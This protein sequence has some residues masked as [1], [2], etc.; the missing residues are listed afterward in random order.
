MNL[1]V[2]RCP[3][4]TSAHT[5]L[6]HEVDI[7]CYYECKSC[8]VIFISPEVLE[9]VD[10]GLGLVHYTGSYWGNELYSSRE[11]S[12]GSSLARVAELFLYAR[13]PINKFIDIA[14]GPGY[15]LDSLK[16]QLPSSDIFY[17]NELFPPDPEFCTS[18]SNYLRGS[19]LDFTF[20]FEAGCCIEVIE[21][22]SPRMVKQLFIDLAQRSKENS[23]YIFNTGLA[24]Y[25]KKE[26]IGYLDPLERGHIMG[27]SIKSLQHL[28]KPIGFNIQPIPGKTWAFIAEYKTNHDF[29]GPLLDR[30]WIA[31]KENVNILK[32]KKTGDLMYVL[33]LDTARAYL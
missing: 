29:A 10:A 17:A 23:I 16:H 33:G 20:P 5:S 6:F 31:L 9:R 26:D 18:N 13:I 32:D 4:C 25:I 24:D 7:Y 12:W 15:L 21:H 30:I 28:L 19:I 2:K 1:Q 11:R 14:S 22:L 3:I 27:W 8:E